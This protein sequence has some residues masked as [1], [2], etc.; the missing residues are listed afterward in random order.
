MSELYQSKAD[1]VARTWTKLVEIFGPRFARDY[2]DNAPDAWANVIAAMS[3]AELQNGLSNILKSGSGK[4]L[5]LPEFIKLCRTREEEPVAALPARPTPELP[6][7]VRYGNMSLLVYLTR[8]AKPINEETLQRLVSVKNETV[9]I[10]QS[11]ATEDSVTL[12][13]VRDALFAKWNVIT[14]QTLA[15]QKQP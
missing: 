10:Y 3:S 13:E 11:I 9:K 7:S 4:I 14:K 15:P 2:G 5:A 6:P 8:S 12:D 1:K